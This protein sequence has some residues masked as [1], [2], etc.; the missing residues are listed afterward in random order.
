VKPIQVA[1]QPRLGLLRTTRITVDGIRYRLFRTSV[2]VAVIAMA[3]A[4]LMNILSESLM[5][6]AVA[7]DTREQIARMHT[8]HDWAAR[9]TRPGTPEEII[10]SLSRAE[11]HDAVYRETAAMAKL[12]PEAMAELHRSAR[13]AADILRFFDDLDYA[14]RR[15]LIHAA[16]GAGIFERLGTPTGFE[17]FKT[18]L[19]GMKS[20]RF[21]MRLNDLTRFLSAWPKTLARIEQVRQGRAQAIRNVDA[22]RGGRTILAALAETGGEFGQAV[23]DAGFAFDAQVT[24]PGVADRAQ[25]ILDQRRL[26]KSAESILMLQ[27]IAQRRNVVP[28]DVTVA[29]MWG[30]LRGRRAATWYRGRLG[31]SIDTLKTENQKLARESEELK[32][33]DEQIRKN[34]EQIKLN[35]EKTKENLHTIREKL[36]PAS[37]LTP[38]RMTELARHRNREAALAR[39]ERLTVGMGRGWMGLGERMGWLLFVSMLVCVIGIS[40]AML[41]SVTERFREIATMKCL[42]ALDGFI[43]IM[44]VLESCFLGVV[45]GLIGAV[46]GSLIGL[47]RMLAAFGTTFM[48][49]V[50]VVDLLA[51]MIVAVGLG[52]VLAAVAAVYPSFKAARLAPMEAM[53]VE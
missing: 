50:P 36:V 22:A 33:N 39:A 19:A 43:M 31:Q 17:Q 15:A 8:V 42:G 23:R 21:I 52:V 3:V 45:G 40:N 10:A 11:E 48:A 9:L 41:M 51:A 29:M 37:D 14:R 24:A 49:S 1:D 32:K 46:L 13:E 2:T 30:L 27:A 7:H 4:F 47:G 26:E 34:N 38:E 25:R 6:R 5:K 16:S 44:F 12:T 53:R 18:A 35:D 20:V 28:T